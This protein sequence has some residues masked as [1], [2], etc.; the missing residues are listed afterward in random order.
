M[1]WGQDIFNSVFTASRKG[2]PL[3]LFFLLP[4]PILLD[5]KSCVPPSFRMG[6][7]DSKDFCRGGSSRHVF[8]SALFS[9]R[10]FFLICLCSVLYFLLLVFVFLRGKSI[11]ATLWHLPFQRGRQYPGL[12]PT[13]P[14]PLTLIDCRLSSL[15]IGRFHLLF[16]G[17]IFPY[18]F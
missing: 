13:S 9:F 14:P 12:L 2:R 1:S 6:Q 3:I 4:R 18:L 5:L 16:E 17:W 7:Q 11:L 15:P 10:M 8:F